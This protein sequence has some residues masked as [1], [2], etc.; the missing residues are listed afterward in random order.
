[1][2]KTKPR[3]TCDVSKE[4]IVVRSPKYTTPVLWFPAT[5]PAAG[6]YPSLTRKPTMNAQEHFT[7][8]RQCERQFEQESIY[9]DV[10]FFFTLICFVGNFIYVLCIY[11]R[12]Y[13]IQ[14]DFKTRISSCR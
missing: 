9:N 7:C 11:L 4:I 6:R 10:W 14:H 8:I 1:M 13:G 12:K 2:I 5:Y 3:N